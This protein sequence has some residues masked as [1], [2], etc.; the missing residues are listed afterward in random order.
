M[1]T[2]NYR[3]DCVHYALKNNGGYLE[4]PLGVIQPT[5]LRE[6]D[7]LRDD[8]TGR[9]VASVGVRHDDQELAGVLDGTRE[10]DT[11]LEQ[12]AGRYHATVGGQ[13]GVVVS[14]LGYSPG[15]QSL[16]SHTEPVTVRARYAVPHLVGA[17]VQ[18]LDPREPVRV[19]IP[20]ASREHH[21]HVYSGHGHAHNRA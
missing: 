20:A 19:F 4:N 9:H 17:R 13:P 15:Q 6:V 3:N 18:V 2:L 14:S 1:Y 21:A 10:R 7:T 11:V 12:P 5:G 16:H 8:V